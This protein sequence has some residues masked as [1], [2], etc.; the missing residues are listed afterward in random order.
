MAL[1]VTVLENKSIGTTGFTMA[2]LLLAIT[3]CKGVQGDIRAPSCTPVALSFEG[4]VALDRFQLRRAV[5]DE[6]LDLSRHPESEAPVFDASLNIEDLYVSE[7]FPRV[8][9]RYVIEREEPKTRLNVK[10]KIEEGPRVIVR[11]LRI[12][13]TRAFRETELMKLWS[14]QSS[15]SFGFGKPLYYHRQLGALADDIRAKYR[16]SGFLDV[17]VKPPEITWAADGESVEV[18]IDVS[19]GPRYRLRHVVYADEFRRILEGD[20]VPLRMGTPFTSALLESERVR[21]TTLLRRLGYPE[22]LVEITRKRVAGPS[23]RKEAELDVEFGG[24]AGK[25]YRIV[26][27]DVEGNQKTMRST[28]LGKISQEL[29]KLYNGD[30]VDASLRRLY[31]SGLFRKA[32]LEVREVSPG[33]AKL[34]AVLDE[35]DSIEVQFLAGYGAYEQA[36]VKAKFEETNLFGTGWDFIAQ[37][38][39][40]MKDVRGGANFVNP[41][42]FETELRMNIG[43]EF[44]RREEPS[45][46][47]KGYRTTLSFD[48]RLWRKLHGRIGY[49]YT[50]RQGSS[51]RVP[52]VD[53]D[54]EDYAKGE[55]FIEFRYDAR[56]H[57]IFTTKGHS[58]TLGFSVSDPSLAGDVDF[59]RLIARST[60]YVPIGENTRLVFHAESGLL[61]P[62]AGSRRLPLQERFFNGGPNTVRS[63]RQSDIGAR[64]VNGEQLGGEFR[65]ILSGEFRFPL[66][67]PLEAA[68]FVDAGNL[69]QKVQDY[70]F[71]DLRYAIGAGLRYFLPIGP[72][73]LDAGYNPKRRL[74]EDIW[75]L[76]LSVGVPF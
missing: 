40:S 48:R 73:R 42:L 11:K 19:E 32:K 26:D 8:K 18:R 15:G 50:D 46:I 49:S 17:V 53:A 33:D 4:N 60:L 63:F 56:D 14:R 36:R 52:E 74:G 39:M 57:P 70:D 13:G 69:G 72:I 59:H 41:T 37:G 55:G 34:V 44:F 28:V 30:E 7:G 65:N 62:K 27:I 61:F 51:A 2:C 3:S 76:H 47:D 1:Q 31:R 29:G 16:V 35:A 10:F 22:P 75:V 64:S 58:H 25:R 71:R 54:L 67:L 5:K 38:R 20:L 45:F 43:G 68:L 9:V 6:M 21:L 66:H 23:G 12:A 24:S